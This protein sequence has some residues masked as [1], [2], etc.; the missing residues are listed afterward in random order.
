M[1]SFN[2]YPSRG[3]ASLLVTAQYAA[4]CRSPI[5]HTEP[6]V[7]IILIMVTV[8]SLVSNLRILLFFAI[9]DGD[10]VVASIGI[11]LSAAVVVLLLNDIRRLRKEVEYED[12]DRD[13]E[14][15]C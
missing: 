14:C 15:C 2:Y 9:G 6:C 10:R 13:S 12:I 7:C 5:R 4:S 11:G 8:I 1:L 3:Y